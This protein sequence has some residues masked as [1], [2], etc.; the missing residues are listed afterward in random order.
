MDIESA[1]PEA[2]FRNMFE[3]DPFFLELRRDPLFQEYV[4]THG[5]RMDWPA[6]NDYLKARA[7]D[8]T[9]EGALQAQKAEKAL[10]YNLAKRNLEV[11][12]N[13]LR[14]ANVLTDAPQTLSKNPAL[15]KIR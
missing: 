8:G 2:V 6:S 12:E 7:L 11:E 15:D 4:R 14:Q 13:L 5:G 1:A 9:G 10:R 3:T